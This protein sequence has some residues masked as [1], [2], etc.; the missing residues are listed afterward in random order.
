MPEAL[1]G[2]PVQNTWAV[3]ADGGGSP[4]LLV[5]KAYSLAVLR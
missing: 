5:P 2:T 3:P 4:R 1:S